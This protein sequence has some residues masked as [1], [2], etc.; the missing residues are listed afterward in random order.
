M[1]TITT[2]RTRLGTRREGTALL[3]EIEPG[4]S[5]PGAWLRTAGF[6]SLFVVLATAVQLLRQPGVPS[7][8][9]VIAEDG[10]VFLTDA[11]NHPIG[12][13]LL[14]PY[15]GYL[16][17]VPRLLAALTV[18]FPLRYAALLLTGSS[19]VVVSLL[20]LYVWSSSR[21]LFRT[22]WAR[23]VVVAFL[24]LLPTAGYETNASLN[25]LHWYLDF[26]CFW[27]VFAR[28]RR[29]RELAVG[30]VIVAAAALCDP[31]VGLLLPL[32]V[33]STVVSLRLRE[34]ALPH[35]RAALLVPGAYL[36]GLA[37]QFAVG[38]S[39]RPPRAFVPVS[40]LDL[41]GIYGFRVAG[42]LL[43]GD[44]F[45][46]RLFG[47]Y[48]LVFA[49]VCLLVAAGAVVTAGLATRHWV[50]ARVLVAAGYSALLFAVP[51]LLRGTSIYLERSRIRLDGSRYMVV[52]A[53]LL[54]VALVL[55]VDRPGEHPRSPHPSV[56][57]SALIV[58]VGVLLG[59]NY[60]VHSVREAGPQWR[61]TVS[62]AQQ[63]C[64]RSGGRPGEVGA[65]VNDPLAPPFRRDQVLLPVAPIARGTARSLWN[66]V[67]DCRRLT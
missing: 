31:L 29:R 24:L 64:R 66:V 4:G 54:V 37:V 38:T 9:T 17:V 65:S 30:A 23:A 61:Q 67:V 56:F 53:L 21:S 62:D 40:W 60:S 52:P 49:Y 32:V 14:R 26:A 55:A 8:N 39:D 46:V 35:P 11:L 15:E 18:A 16:H 28:P 3:P 7:W 12:A 2:R 1:T 50:R 41:P 19:A 47:A 59:V 51:L 27:V 48:G 10:A 13:T 63:R 44:K 34:R 33:A 45:L 6:G 43:V 5:R 57:R 42:S 22:R 20:A 36:A 58:L 25:N